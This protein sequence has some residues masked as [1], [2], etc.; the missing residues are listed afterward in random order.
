MKIET[1]QTAK[2]RRQS[3]LRKERAEALKP[4]QSVEDVQLA[5]LKEASKLGLDFAESMKYVKDKVDKVAQQDSQLH[6]KFRCQDKAR[7]AFL[8]KP[9]S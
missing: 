7:E 2:Y 9:F 8:R 1:Y 6:P 3:K 4:K 5:A